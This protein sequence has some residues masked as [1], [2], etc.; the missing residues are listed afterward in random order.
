MSIKTEWSV[1]IK[2]KGKEEV[3]KK[4]FEDP[5]E[6]HDYLE[7]HKDIIETADGKKLWLWGIK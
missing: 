4:T 5:I 7:K 6:L 1:L 3:Q 2:F